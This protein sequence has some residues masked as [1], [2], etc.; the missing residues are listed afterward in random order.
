MTKLVI[1]DVCHASTQEVEG[2]AIA[3]AR[4]VNTPQ[5][6]AF[7]FPLRVRVPE[8]GGKSGVDSDGDQEVDEG[9]VV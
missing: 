3:A 2:I 5:A 9:R 4:N 7:L 1:V 6:V 8:Q